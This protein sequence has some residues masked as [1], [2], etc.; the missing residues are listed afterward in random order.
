MIVARTLAQLKERLEEPSKLGALDLRAE[1]AALFGRPSPRHVSRDILLRGMAYR[2][3][4]QMYGGLKRATLKQLKRLAAELRDGGSIAPAPTALLRPGVR[5]LRE[6]NGET[7]IVEVLP[8]GFAWRGAQYQSL[9]A[10]ARAITGV[11]WSGPKFFGLL[12]KHRKEAT[13]LRDLAAALK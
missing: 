11:Q 12:D 8:D 2:L 4:E 10:I 3:Q 1:W 9:S 5:L 6:W 7:Q 13:D